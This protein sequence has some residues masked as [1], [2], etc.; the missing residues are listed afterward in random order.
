[1]A[2]LSVDT[3]AG[4]RT[5]I[6]TCGF[7]EYTS[8]PKP[9]GAG[10]CDRVALRYH[11]AQ[12]VDCRRKSKKGRGHRPCDPFASTRRLIVA[13]R[14]QPVDHWEGHSRPFPPTGGIR[15]AVDRG[16]APGRP[17]LSEPLQ[18]R[19]HDW[20]SRDAEGGEQRRPALVLR[21]PLL[22]PAHEF[23]SVCTVNLFM[24]YACVDS[25]E[26]ER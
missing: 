15:P 5:Q 24:E 16:S 14:R 8:I 7:A 22:R 20:C 21:Y 25:M 13:S 2:G 9:P 10:R 4:C 23:H 26:I 1:M 19:L 18:R 3:E 11:G 6:H 17:V 12:P